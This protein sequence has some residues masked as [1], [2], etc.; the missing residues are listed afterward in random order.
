MTS[1]IQD[2]NDNDNDNGFAGD[3][4]ALPISR[5]SDSSDNEEYKTSYSKFAA[6]G[7]QNAKSKT[8]RRRGGGYGNTTSVLEGLPTEALPKEDENNG[9]DFCVD[10]DDFAMEPASGKTNIFLDGDDGDDNGSDE[11]SDDA[12]RPYDGSDLEMDAAEGG[13]ATDSDSDSDLEDD[14]DDCP[15]GRTRRLKETVPAGLAIEQDESGIENGDETEGESGMAGGPE[16]DDGDND[17]GRFSQVDSMEVEAALPAF[18]EPADEPPATG[19]DASESVDVPSAETAAKSTEER[20]AEPSPEPTKT[21]TKIIQSEPSTLQILT[22]VDSLYLQATT[23]GTMDTMT[24]GDI[25]RSVA[26]HFGIAKLGKPQKKLV[27][28]RLTGLITGEVTIGEGLAVYEDEME[29]NGGKEVESEGKE[30]RKKGK[31]KKKKKSK[32]GKM[33]K[34]QV[35]SEEEEEEMEEEYEEA[36]EEE[37]RENDSSSDYDEAPPTKSKRASRSKSNKGKLSKHLKDRHAKARARRMEEARIRKEELGHLAED[38]D[39]DDG[40]GGAK[41]GKS[42]GKDVKGEEGEENEEEEQDSGPKISEEDKQRALA[43]AARFDTNRE[44]LRMKRMEDRVGLID[45]LRMKR[46]ENIAND[47]ESEESVT[48]SNMANEKV[49]KEVKPEDVGEVKKEGTEE[50]SGEDKPRLSSSMGMA[51]ENKSEEETEKPAKAFMVD[52]E[53]DSSDE[54]SSDD[55]DLEISAPSKENSVTNSQIATSSKPAKKISA[56]EML[57]TSKAS[58]RQAPKT[59]KPVMNPRMAM[60]NALRAKTVQAGN[61]WLAK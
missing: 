35:Q 61:R 50:N 19:S 11:D 28:G 58:I 49:E 52:L 29:E 53:D 15:R 30:N 4:M 60:R 23:A 36:D 39:D 7:A 54:E 26:T 22:R 21:T 5:D 38:D 42:K 3:E 57:F 25:N 31:D 59:S 37:A 24:V 33:K 18:P 1:S 32:K 12:T 6:V 43:I 8:V 14:A 45:R 55:D 17:E 40:D 51:Q 34:A 16:A 46:L 13:A 10:M 47:A 2:E 44:E 20:S 27:K 9:H 48:L 41:K 56:M